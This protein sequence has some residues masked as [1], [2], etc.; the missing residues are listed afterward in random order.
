MISDHPWQ[1]LFTT[2]RMANYQYQYW[3]QANIGGFSNIGYCQQN[4]PSNFLFIC[5]Q[6][7]KQT[8][9]DR[10]TFINN[11]FSAFIDCLQTL[12]YYARFWIKHSIVRNLKILP[13]IE[14]R[15]RY[16]NYQISKFF[17]IPDIATRW[18][19]WNRCSTT[20]QTH[21]AHAGQYDIGPPLLLSFW[22]L[23]YGK[24]N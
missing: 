23:Q 13:G 8:L 4:F 21:V 17:E 14:Y 24:Q 22:T 11:H 16:Q 6:M 10:L 12:F 1:E 19:K 7:V 2:P 5:K 18:E 20:H 3:Y 9:R 15:Y